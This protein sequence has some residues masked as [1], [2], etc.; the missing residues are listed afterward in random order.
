[1]MRLRMAAAVAFLATVPL[2]G[3]ETYN[4]YHH[5]LPDERR[6]PNIP[7]RSGTVSVEPSQ[8]YEEIPLAPTPVF[9]LPHRDME[10]RKIAALSQVR[11]PGPGGAVPVTGG[12]TITVTS[13]VCIN[14]TSSSNAISCP[15]GAS[16]AVGDLAIFKSKVGF[17][18]GTQTP[19]WTFSGTSSC[20]PTTVVAPVTQ[21]N[22]GGT[23]IETIS[24]CI[25]TTAG[26]NT[27][28]ITWTAGSFVDIEAF[29][30][31]TTNTWKTVFVDQ[32][33]NNI[34]A[35]TSTSCPTGTT[36]ATTT[37]NDFIL[38][39]CDVFNVG[40]TWGALAGFT[41]YAAASRNT[42]GTYYKVVTSTGT[43]T[44]TIPLSTTDFGVGVI[45][46]FASN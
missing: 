24:A 8:L 45:V 29:T 25:I 43:Q 12:P 37:A 21:S 35:T 38:A 15:F 42:A 39:T 28:L 41:Q 44:A 36:A 16:G 18:G 40:Q 19:T 22:G 2:F 4:R 9:I 11:I 20:T 13:A 10:P 23:F 14:S 33:Q 32:T 3:Q 17:V 30:V 1:M 46:A 6:P 26:A 31:H 34:Q 7:F 5:G 27:P